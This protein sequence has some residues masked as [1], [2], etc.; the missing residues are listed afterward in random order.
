VLGRTSSAKKDYHRTEVKVGTSGHRPFDPAYLVYPVGFLVSP[1]YLQIKFE[2]LDPFHLNQ[3]V[4]SEISES[5]PMTDVGI[6]SGC[7]AEEA[8]MLCNPGL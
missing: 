4:I 3:I 6:E 2:M 1:P 5:G 8:R 7:Q